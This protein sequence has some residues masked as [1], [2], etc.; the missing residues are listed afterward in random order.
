MMYYMFPGPSTLWTSETGSWGCRDTPERRFCPPAWGKWWW[1]GGG[2]LACSRVTT[3]RRLLKET[4]TM[5]GRDV[6][7]LAWVS[8]KSFL[9]LKFPHPSLAA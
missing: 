3:M 9:Y 5:V 2:H 4:M 6:V 1:W 8:P 7:Q